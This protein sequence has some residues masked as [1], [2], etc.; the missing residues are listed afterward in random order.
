MQPLFEP[1]LEAVLNAPFILGS[2]SMVED[3][4][5]QTCHR[6]MN[7]ISSNS[8][9]V[10]AGR[11]ALRR[12]TAI[13]FLLCGGVAL[14]WADDDHEQARKAV[15]AGQVLPLPTVLERLQRSHPG[16]VLDLQLEREDG[17]WIY[18]IKLLQSDGQLLKVELDAATAQ[19]LKVKR[20]DEAKRKPQ[21]VRETRP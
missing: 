11:Q 4:G 15:Q 10:G 18:E 17:R 5:A 20:K 3:R 12:R 21:E 2:A 8:S 6:D 16:Q 13:A 7:T 9:T 14:A 1:A 19:V